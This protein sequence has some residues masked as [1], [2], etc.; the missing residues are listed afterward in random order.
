MSLIRLTCDYKGYLYRFGVF[1]DDDKKRWFI[2]N[3]FLPLLGAK[4][5]AEANSLI[6]DESA[7]VK[8]ET[9]IDRSKGTKEA[10]EKKKAQWCVSL[11]FVHEYGLYALMNISDDKEMANVRDFLLNTLIPLIPMK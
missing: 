3:D 6:K 11:D 2:L 4:L 1:V 5:Y 8:W 10:K 9:L 7:Q